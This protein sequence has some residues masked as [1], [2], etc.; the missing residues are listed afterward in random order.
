MLAISY[1]EGLQFGE[2]KPEG[3]TAKSGVW[4]FPMIC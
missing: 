3:P 2:Q 4:A 1:N